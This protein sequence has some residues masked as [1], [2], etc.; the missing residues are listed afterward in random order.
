MKEKMIAR[1]QEG[2]HFQ[3]LRGEE[4][5]Y[6]ASVWGEA[7]IKG[8]EV[9]EFHVIISYGAMII[10]FFHVDEVEWITERKEK[11]ESCRS[12]S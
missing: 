9:T 2:L 1:L 8:G 6:V 11:L 5:G 3:E 4:T 10:A 12:G 7:K